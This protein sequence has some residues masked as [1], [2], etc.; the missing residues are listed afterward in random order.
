M[1]ATPM[2]II[3]VFKVFNLFP[4]KSL[5]ITESITNYWL[6]LKRINKMLIRLK[7]LKYYI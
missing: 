7:G 5:S 4:F 3:K 2:R 6:A 1:I